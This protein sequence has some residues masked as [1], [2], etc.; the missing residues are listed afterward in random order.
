MLDL[1]KYSKIIVANWKMNGSFKF[2]DDFSEKI[3]LF[4]KDS[5]FSWVLKLFFERLSFLFPSEIKF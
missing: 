2:I 4:S 5:E 3:A 1:E